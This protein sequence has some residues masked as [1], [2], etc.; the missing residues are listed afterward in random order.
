MPET[1]GSPPVKSCCCWLFLLVILALLEQG[2]ADDLKLADGTVMHDVIVGDNWN[3]KEVSVRKLG[4]PAEFVPWD[5][6]DRAEIAGIKDRAWARRQEHKL[7]AIELQRNRAAD[8]T[9]HDTLVKLRGAGVQM[10]VKL[11]QIPD[12]WRWR[13][14]LRNRTRWR[15]SFQTGRRTT[16]LRSESAARDKRRERSD[17]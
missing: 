6:I 14:C 3:D 2:S 7:A 4:S 15:A 11:F 5:R 17:I 9:R 12:E 8:T 1:V 16:N 13:A 10:T